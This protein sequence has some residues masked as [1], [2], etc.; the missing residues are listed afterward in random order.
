MKI[1]E[2]FLA[3]MREATQLLQTAGPMAATAE[4]Q[5]A[6]RGAG[7]PDAGATTQDWTSLLPG[8]P[9]FVDINPPSTP[10]TESAASAGQ[11]ALR[12]FT[13]A[14]RNK[15]KGAA[16]RQPIQDVEVDA[17]L[18]G[19]G[20]FLSGSVSNQAGTRAYKLYVPS[21]YTEQA[22]PLVVMLHGCKQNPNDFAAGTDM[23]T[24]AEENNCFVLYPGQIHAANGSNCWNWFKGEDQQR[25]RGEPSIIADMT[26]EVMREYKIDASRVYVTGLSAGG[27]MAAVMGA[28]YPELYAAVGI[29]SGLPYGVAHDMP[30]AFAAMNGGQGKT[31]PLAGRKAPAAL[32]Q[33]IPVIVFHGDRDATV[34]PA[35][36]EQALVQCVGV[37]SGETKR[38]EGRVPNGRAYTRTLCHDAAGKVVAEH[39]MVHGQGHAWS[40][41]SSKGSYTDP[42]GPSAAREMLR[43]FY[44]Q[45]RNAA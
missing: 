2:H 30:S 20:K 23:N 42:K 40:G 15:W 4:I 28:T 11:E 19:K 44:S 29:H 14:A 13:Q 26:R 37:A 31:R 43:F 12:R 34:N 45:Q 3:Q 33:T 36:G 24:V 35:N 25:D 7:M 32:G 38:E 5:R 9:Q 10:Q 6:L 27:A 18:A 21:A 22:L 1:N 41:G 16:A 39:W 8:A 17:D